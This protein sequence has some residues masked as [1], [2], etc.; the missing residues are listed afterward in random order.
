[1]ASPSSALAAYTPSSTEPS[2][3]F[4][5]HFLPLPLKRTEA[6]PELPS[7]IK[8][9]ISEHF[10]DTHP[11]AYASDATQLYTLRREWLQGNGGPDI[12]PTSLDGLTL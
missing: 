10:R 9:Y 6:A 7:R 4:Q 5:K 8:N 11:E 1:M 12:H 3:L 2:Y